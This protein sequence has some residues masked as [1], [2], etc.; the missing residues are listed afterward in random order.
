MGRTLTDTDISCLRKQM[1]SEVRLSFPIA[2]N[3][4]QRLTNHNMI[5]GE[6]NAKV[7]PFNLKGAPDLQ[8]MA[9]EYGYSYTK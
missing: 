6:S 8:A 9:D 2:A 3:T 1:S 5:F 7:I 4:C